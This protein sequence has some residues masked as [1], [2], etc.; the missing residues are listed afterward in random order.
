MSGRIPPR[1]S[2][3]CGQLRRRATTAC[4]DAERTRGVAWLEPRLQAEISYSE[5]MQ[6]GGCETQCSRRSCYQAERDGHRLPLLPPDRPRAFFRV[7]LRRDWRDRAVFTVASFHKRGS[8]PRASWP[9]RYR[10][11]S[12]RG[13]QTVLRGSA[14]G[15]GSLANAR[16]GRGQ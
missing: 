2:C 16:L 15:R 5:M 13:S 9:E 11:R 10:G 7:P 6:G 4:A 3:G 14:R 8:C 12:L 1:C